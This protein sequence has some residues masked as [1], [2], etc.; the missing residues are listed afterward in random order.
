MQRKTVILCR[1]IIQ[2]ENNIVLGKHLQWKDEEPNS[3]HP[4]AA[5]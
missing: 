2:K 4:P 1:K 5:G 3:N